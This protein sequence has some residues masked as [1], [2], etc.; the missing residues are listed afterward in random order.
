MFCKCGNIIP[1]KGELCD[2]CLE[3]KLLVKQRVGIEGFIRWKDNREQRIK[4]RLK[5]PRQ[6]YHHK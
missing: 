3:E 5:K 1:G 6:S 2:E 4:A